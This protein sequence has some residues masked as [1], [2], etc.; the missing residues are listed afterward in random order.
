MIFLFTS[1][2]NQESIMLKIARM[3]SKKVYVAPECKILLLKHPL[4][5]L[6]DPSFD[7]EAEFQDLEEYDGEWGQ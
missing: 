3:T 1:S 4:N 6:K 7:H 5:L 2:P